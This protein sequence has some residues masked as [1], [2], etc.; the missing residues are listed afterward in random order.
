[1]KD[2]VTEDI[3]KIIKERSN[4]I[5]YYLINDPRAYVPEKNSFSLI[6]DDKFV[7][8]ERI[9]SEEN[10]KTIFL[11]TGTFRIFDSA[12]SIGELVNYAKPDKSWNLK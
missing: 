12:L 8:L 6:T 3:F 2:K 10:K 7:I 4:D 5:I 9:Q 11:F 1:M